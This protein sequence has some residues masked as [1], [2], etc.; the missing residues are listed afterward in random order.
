MNVL[1][2][3]GIEPGALLVNIVGFVVLFLILRKWAFAPIS[4]VL[5]SRARQI[6][7][8]VAKAEQ[9]RQQA[10]VELA[11]VQRR[12]QQLL[13]AVDQEAEQLRRKVRAEA[14]ALV[15]QARRAARER[16]LQAERNITAAVEQA[17][18][19]LRA[20]V[21]TL[22]VEFCQRLLAQ[23]LDA[24]RQQALLDAFIADVEKMAANAGQN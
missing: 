24:E 20:E 4:E 13:A 18:Q 21:S 3:L 15:E 12:R 6:A 11:S 9:A 10:E 2:Q 7:D 23:S 19:Q 17:R 22:A 16:E 8:D 14:Q 1:E 5:A